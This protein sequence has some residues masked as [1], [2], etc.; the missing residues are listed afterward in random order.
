MRQQN[1]GRQFDRLPADDSERT[2]SNRA[3]REE[4]LSFFEDRFGIP[5]HTF[6]AYSFWEKGKGKVW[7]FR[8]SIASPVRVEALG[9]HVL[10]TRQRFW[11]P[12]TDGM[13]RFGDDATNNVIVVSP[14]EAAAFWRGDTQSIDTS[15]EDGYVLVAQTLVDAPVPLGVG[16]YIDGVLQSV[17]PKSRQRK[18]APLPVNDEPA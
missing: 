18:I 10:R 8:G 4:V 15:A 11:K 6:E 16:L 5:P 3:T 13:Q 7:A 12:T 17:V 2:V 14:D 9:I 1:C